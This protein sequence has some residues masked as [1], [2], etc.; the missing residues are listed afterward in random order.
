MFEPTDIP[1]VF[2]V[3]PG[4]DFPKALVDGLR[5][6]LSGK[7]PEDTARVDVILNTSRMAR[8]VSSLFDD[9]PA[10]LLPRIRVLGDFSRGVAADLPPAV[11]P[12]R[13]RFELIQLITRLLDQEPDLASRASIYDLADSLAGL[14]DEMAGEGV[15]IDVIETLDVSDQSGHWA[16]AQ[17]FFAIARH[18]LE[19]VDTAPG[20]EARQR[21]AIERLVAKWADNPPQHP[22]V[23]AGSTGSRGTMMLLMQAVAKLPQGAVVLPGF[24][25]DMPSNVWD[26]M[27]DALEAEDHP[28]F[29]FRRLMD[30]VSIGPQKVQPWHE[31]NPPNPARNKLISLALRPAPV[32]DQWLREGPSLGS[33]SNA[34]K[35]LTLIEATTQREE[36]LT[37]AARMRKAA[38]EGQTCALITPD[39]MLTRQVSAALDRWR[40]I[41]DD[42]AGQP[43]QL[44]P[45]G[46]F[47]RH[48]SSLF[49]RKLTS[50]TLLALLKHPLTHS[51]AE[52]G[53]HL[54]WTREL[55]LWIRRKAITY[56]DADSLLGW[57][58]TQDFVKDTW[59]DWLVTS[60]C[61]K[62]WTGDVDLAQRLESH[63]KLAE[64]IAGGQSDGSGE[65][66]LEGSGRKAAQV[67]EELRR[68]SDVAGPISASDYSDMFGAIL[69]REE[70]RDRD[71]G[72]PNILIWGTLEARVQGADLVILGGLNEGSWPE[73]PNPDPWLNRKMRHDAGLLLPERRIGLSAHD[74]QQAVCAPEVWITRSIRSDEA[75][76]VPS[77]WVNRLLNLLGGLPEQNGPEALEDMRNR[78]REWINHVRTLE[79][80]RE[81]LPETRPSPVPPKAA[82][83]HRLS[84]TEIKRLI[85]DP[86]AIYAKHV[87]RLRPMDPLMRTPDALLRGIVVHEI[88]EQLIKE[89]ADNGISVTRERLMAISE[90]VLA[91]NVPWPTA[92]ALWK[93]RLERIADHIVAQEALRRQRALPFAFEARAQDRIEELDFTLTGTADRLDRTPDGDLILYDYKTGTPPSADEQTYFDKQLLLEAAMAEHG[94][95]AEIDPADV[96]DAIY[97]GLGPK[98]K[99]QPAPLAE[100][101]P[102]RVWEEFTRLIGAYLTD[103]KGFT[104]RR[105]MRTEADESDYDQLAR[106]GEWDAT[107]DP[108]PEVLI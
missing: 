75:E 30:A 48:V 20:Q 32:T 24:D 45:P 88:L 71:E 15:P 57:G 44:S 53:N 65:L 62:E 77:R 1:R 7:P 100:T 27:S 61:N 69:A 41:P 78:G 52:R 98:P 43:L 60:F 4:A 46:R 94:A 25:T 29:R 12:L 28:Q 5:F 10:I 22:V 72:H 68:H 40:L 3:Q 63:I 6:R 59:M 33:L 92:R 50:E 105:A 13:Q 87:L 17:H 16:R 91:K 21:L 14:F 26:R 11:S 54:L 49:Q 18:F 90:T 80:F 95:F 51:G 106:F 66:W 81:V 67:I 8:R 89:S 93:A 86:Y 37:I 79:T 39:R 19:N 56:P 104:A 107:D 74:F 47:L 82:R 23:L 101:P 42:S 73:S 31:C 34:V 97:I 64:Q 2:G 96:A 85:R 108:K 38:E 103:G 76:T 35:D 36:A 70:V 83:P 58:R 99:D 55:E 84:V 102:E 9:G